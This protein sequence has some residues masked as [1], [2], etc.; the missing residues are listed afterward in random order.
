[1]LG[2]SHRFRLVVFALHI[3]ISTMTS[4]HQFF[5]SRARSGFVSRLAIHTVIVADVLLLF[6]SVLV[7]SLF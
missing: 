5:G 7:S 1:M 6:K 4:L 3:S 2:A